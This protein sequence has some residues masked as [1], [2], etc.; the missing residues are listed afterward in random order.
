M[1]K[2]NWTSKMGS[3]KK[4]LQSGWG[5]LLWL[6]TLLLVMYYLRAKFG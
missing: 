6:N 1:N 4:V 5:A 3:L 2:E